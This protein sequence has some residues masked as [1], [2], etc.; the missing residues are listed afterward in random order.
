MTPGPTLGN[1]YGKP[2]PF[3]GGLQCALCAVLQ[4]DAEHNGALM[5]VF[6]Q[7]VLDGLF[8]TNMLRKTAQL[9][10]W[11]DVYCYQSTQVSRADVPDDV[12]VIQPDFPVSPLHCVAPAVHVSGDCGRVFASPVIHS[13]GRLSSE[14]EMIT[15]TAAHSRP[16]TSIVD[17]IEAHDG[18]HVTSS[19]SSEV[20]LPS[21][22]YNRVRDLF[23]KS[24]TEVHHNRL[25]DTSSNNTSSGGMQQNRCDD[26]LVP[27]AGE[28]ICTIA[29]SC[30]SDPSPL[31]SSYVDAGRIAYLGSDVNSL[32]TASVMNAADV[33]VV[34]ACI[35]N[36]VNNVGELR[37]AGVFS[38]QNDVDVTA[39]SEMT[40][41]IQLCCQE[42]YANSTLSCISAKNPQL[43]GQTVT[44]RKLRSPA[45]SSVHLNP[46]SG[47][48]RKR[49]SLH[50]EILNKSDVL[51]KKTEKAKCGS[52]KRRL[53]K[54]NMLME[55]GIVA[56]QSQNLDANFH[57][58][59]YNGDVDG[60]LHGEKKSE[61]PVR[62]DILSNCESELSSVEVTSSASTSVPA[63]VSVSTSQISSNLAIAS[64]D[65]VSESCQNLVEV[66]RIES[67]TKQLAINNKTGLKSQHVKSLRKSSPAV[68][69]D[70][71]SRISSGEQI[72]EIQRSTT[73][74][75]GTDL[76]NSTECDVTA[77][78][79]T[80]VLSPAVSNS[81]LCIVTGSVAAVPSPNIVGCPVSLNDARN[82][83]ML[84]V[85]GRL[86][87]CVNVE[88]SDTVEHRADGAAVDDA[89]AVV[90][91]THSVSC[92]TSRNR[93][94]VAATKHTRTVSIE[95]SLEMLS[96]VTAESDCSP[97]VRH[98]NDTW[99][100]GCPQYS[101]NDAIASN[102]QKHNLEASKELISVSSVS[103]THHP[104]TD[105]ADSNS[106]V[107]YHSLGRST[108]QKEVDF[109][110][111]SG[112]TDLKSVSSARAVD[113][114]PCNSALN[115]SGT[116]RDRDFDDFDWKKV[117][118]RTTMTSAARISSTGHNKNVV[119]VC[120]DTSDRHELT[121]EVHCEEKTSS[122]EG[123][124]IT[125]EIT[126]EG[127]SQSLLCGQ[128]QSGGSYF[129][130]D[131]TA[132]VCRI[133]AV[134]TPFLASHSC[135]LQC[136]E[137]CRIAEESLGYCRTST[138]T[139]DDGSGG[140]NCQLIQSE[141]RSTSD[142]IASFKSNTSSTCRNQQSSGVVTPVSGM[143]DVPVC[144]SANAAVVS[145]AEAESKQSSSVPSVGTSK[146][147]LPTPKNSLTCYQ[148]VTSS[149]AAAAASDESLATASSQVQPNYVLIQVS[150]F[151]ILKLF[152]H[153]IK[154]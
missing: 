142:L 64:V 152:Y 117:Q 115:E 74:V 105:P 2:L 47:S 106:N 78:F 97:L 147:T 95:T 42:T 48:K 6:D 118:R 54:Q 13:A 100:P 113:F 70:E 61:Q 14:A 43:D 153:F 114:E 8:T 18:L 63:A 93:T 45:G 145:D 108:S 3:K 96:S 58:D 35:E 9:R 28:I 122:V 33:P 84:T 37:I 10:R 88:L 16:T 111:C 104:G 71:C 4:D 102:T 15:V 56:G 57:V 77:V 107:A 89:P 87:S 144:I 36:V 59:M 129:L 23:C 62:D 21:A 29:L 112:I 12:V 20:N 38:L 130:P 127:S 101:S 123:L 55:E 44:K 53:Y 72:Q 22:V 126:N 98:D 136:R 110:G 92:E 27:A 146:L 132:S 94:D 69:V 17:C 39:S 149:P 24:D 34:T 79:S 99:I 131:I 148:P 124:C 135:S 86:T 139:D 83:Q 67:F 50:K 154:S 68:V 137:R 116:I 30:I 40:Q 125:S 60:H 143:S 109:P 5:S 7:D 31:D 82:I 150:L 103:N 76:M 73:V 81:G 134:G 66:T 65:G 32:S 80:S 121:S 140:R 90:T 52:K 85:D 51:F 133:S 19:S 41:S 75:A 49:L 119:D 46:L 151:Y 138:T 11:S 141:R 26:E 120:H 128:K 1:E 25:L 91:D